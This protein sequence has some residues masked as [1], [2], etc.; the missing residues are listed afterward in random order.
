MSQRRDRNRRPI[1]FME[2]Q[3]GLLIEHPLWNAD[4]TG[5]WQTYSHVIAGDWP[6]LEQYRYFTTEIGMKPVVDSP[7]G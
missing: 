7:G 3:A 6:I 5:I 2:I 1:H 4:L